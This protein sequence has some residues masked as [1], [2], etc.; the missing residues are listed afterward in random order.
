M[1]GLN[2]KFWEELK[3]LLS[4]EFFNLCGDA[5]N[6]YLPLTDYVVQVLS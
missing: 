2:K 3:P 5:N 4:F 6:E 1:M